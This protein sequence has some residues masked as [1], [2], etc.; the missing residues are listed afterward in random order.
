MKEKQLTTNR[1]LFKYIV[2]TILTFGIYPL[3]VFTKVSNEVNLVAQDGRNSMQYWIIWLLTPITFGIAPLV[4]FH[5]ISNRIGNELR[6]RNISS[7][8]SAST[9]WGWCFFG[10]LLFGIGPFVYIYKFFDASNK[11]NEAYNQD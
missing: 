6:R 10:Y 1:G 9:F 4:W 11:M 2:F 5:N 3:V 7:S 8:F